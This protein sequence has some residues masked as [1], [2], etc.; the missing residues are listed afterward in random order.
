MRHGLVDKGK[1]SVDGGSVHALQNRL[2]Q[3]SGGGLD[4][5]S[6]ALAEGVASSCGKRAASKGRSQ[7]LVVGP[8]AILYLRT[9]VAMLLK[10]AVDLATPH[11]SSLYV[12]RHHLVMTLTYCPLSPHQ[13]HLVASTLLSFAV[14]SHP[15]YVTLDTS[16]KHLWPRSAATNDDGPQTCLARR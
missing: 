15:T 3:V 1:H 11:R 7:E 13:S 16:A 4:H 14:G 9:N 6:V 2:E 12:S 8:L 5:L 10:S